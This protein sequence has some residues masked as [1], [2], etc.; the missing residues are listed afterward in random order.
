MHEYEP[1][2]LSD[3]NINTSNDTPSDAPFAEKVLKE[4]IFY[5]NHIIPSG[6]L[7]KVL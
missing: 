3:S 1:E 6:A 5:N 2:Y 7:I 4:D